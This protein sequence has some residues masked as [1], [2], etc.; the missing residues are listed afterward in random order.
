LRKGRFVV[1]VVVVDFIFEVVIVL[2][3]SVVIGSIMQD[4]R[5]IIL[6]ALSIMVVVDAQMM[7]VIR[8][9]KDSVCLHLLL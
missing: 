4:I 2:G 3:R 7:T 8:M 9:G 5:W 1:V 6:G